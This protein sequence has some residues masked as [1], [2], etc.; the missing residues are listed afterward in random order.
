MRK[1]IWSLAAGDAQVMPP[2]NNTCNTCARRSCREGL[3]LVL[4]QPEN[5]GYG[6]MY[7]QSSLTGRLKQLYEIQQN[8]VK[9]PL[10]AS[11]LP[12]SLFFLIKSGG[13]KQSIL[14]LEFGCET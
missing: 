12:P 13:G 3:S 2:N 1:T 11:I 4:S 5:T 14:G 10:S 9:R 7:L 6:F 8:P